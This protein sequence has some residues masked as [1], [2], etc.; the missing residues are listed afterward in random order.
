VESSG[1]REVEDLG[2]SEKYGNND[3]TGVGQLRG[4]VDVTDLGHGRRN[5]NSDHTMS[6]VGRSQVVMDK[7]LVG[8]DQ[9][10]GHGVVLVNRPYSDSQETPV[11][12][13]VC[14]NDVPVVNEKVCSNNMLDSCGQSV[15]VNVCLDKSLVPVP[16]NI[17]SKLIGNEHTQ[18]LIGLSCDL[19]EGSV[20]LVCG[21]R[22]VF[23][24]VTSV[25]SKYQSCES[26]SSVDLDTRVLHHQLS[27]RQLLR[28]PPFVS[29]MTMQID[30]WRHY[31]QDDFDSSY[32]LNGIEYGFK[33]LD[34]N[35]VIDSF[36]CKNYRRNSLIQLAGKAVR[37]VFTR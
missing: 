7:D 35:V 30:S 21:E 19:A 4:N 1:S 27:S 15:D 12:V 22:N 8:R 13:C 9:D 5:V 31:L 32:L 28:S 2:D 37:L 10:Q 17:V 16:Q 3:Q 18:G 36:H 14:S 24:V 25:A 26:L 33:L 29:S 23:P 34:S 20:D 6:R 11:N